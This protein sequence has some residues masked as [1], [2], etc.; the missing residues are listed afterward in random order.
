MNG[1]VI[2][3]AIVVGLLLIVG[4]SQISALKTEAQDGSQNEFM[5]AYNDANNA[6]LVDVRTPEEYAEGHIPGALNID[7]YSPDFLS[8][9]KELSAGKEV[10][11]YC[12]SGSRSNQARMLLQ[13]EGIHSIDMEGGILAYEGELVR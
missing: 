9:M 6:L 10:Y 4:A 5:K 13:K 1:F 12:R 2:M 7:I 8:K 11:L 3:G